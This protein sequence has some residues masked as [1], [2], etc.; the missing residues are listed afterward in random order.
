MSNFKLTIRDHYK[1][2]IIYIFDNKKKE[3]S[4]I[5]QAQE[6]SQ[7]TK[8]KFQ[9]HILKIKKNAIKTAT[10]IKSLIA[11]KKL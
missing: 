6:H 2:W 9:V 10:T 7:I 11:K 5:F 1:Q 8:Y 3:L 4:E